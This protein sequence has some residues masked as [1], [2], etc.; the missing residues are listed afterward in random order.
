MNILQ[1]VI[2][3]ITWQI[4]IPGKSMT[5]IKQLKSLVLLEFIPK[6]CLKRFIY[7]ILSFNTA[8]E[9]K[10]DCTQVSQ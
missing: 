4:P 9:S 7:R 10:E 8:G 1:F 6:E 3:I 5:V 2:F